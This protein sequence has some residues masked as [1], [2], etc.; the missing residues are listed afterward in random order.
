M[1]HHALKEA[2]H[3]RRRCNLG[4]GPLNT[5]I[6][7]STTTMVALSGH[8]G[9]MELTFVIK[10]ARSPLGAYEAPLISDEAD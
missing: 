3:A 8:T 7:R 1:K 5:T 2:E 10:S 6:G 4:Y 9:K